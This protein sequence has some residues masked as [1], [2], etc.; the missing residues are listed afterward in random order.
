[1][2]D[3]YAPVLSSFLAQEFPGSVTK[4][5]AVFE[6]VAAEIF[7]S[8]QCRFGPMPSPEIQ[9]PVRQVIRHYMDTNEPIQFLV[10]WG[11]SKQGDHGLDVLELS[12]IRNL[13]CLSERV[14]SLY[15][16]GIRITI[17]LEDATDVAL[18]GDDYAPKV[19]TYCYN[20][21]ELVKVLGYY[22]IWVRREADDLMD[23]AEFEKNVAMF[24][25]L[26]EDYILAS[27]RVGT[28]AAQDITSFFV[29][30]Q[31][32]WTGTI[33]LEQRAYYRQAYRIFYP[34]MSEAEITRKIATYF[35]CSLSRVILNGTGKPSSG[36]FIQI[37]YS[38][39]VPGVPTNLASNRIFYRTVPERF[40]NRHKAPWIGRGYVEIANDNSCKI[41][42]ADFNEQ[43]EL[44]PYCFL[45]G[46]AKVQAPFQLK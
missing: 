44:N 3:A 17:R 10:P 23:T 42:L 41:K 32:G 25:P 7:G 27:D 18:F 13:H 40:T 22:E 12:A 16:P 38:L 19:M 35:A 15:A 21:H 11:A 20:F 29:L 39:P 1:M 4:R 5:E 46:D 9:V 31:N 28:A 45:V 14:K 37:N 30:K 2:T 6:A 43:L 8:K 34:D 36:K 33:P 24:R 26:F